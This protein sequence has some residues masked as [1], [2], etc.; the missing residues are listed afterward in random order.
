MAPVLWIVVFLCGLVILPLGFLSRDTYN[1]AF[2]WLIGGSFLF[3]PLGI[4]LGALWHSPRCPVCGNSMHQVDSAAGR[5]AL[6]ARE[7]FR[8]SDPP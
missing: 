1:T 8:N 6:R 2:L 3:I 5:Q 4:L 7:Q